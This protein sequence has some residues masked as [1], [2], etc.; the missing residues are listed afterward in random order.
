MSSPRV[1]VPPDLLA[2]IPQAYRNAANIGDSPAEIARW[3]SERRRNFPTDAV[4]AAKRARAVEGAGRGEEPI[5]APLG[6]M[7]RR[8]ATTTSTTATTVDNVIATTTTKIAASNADDDADDANSVPEEEPVST[9]AVTFP[10][11]RKNTSSTSLG[12]GGQQHPCRTF[13]SKGK[14]RFGSS[15]RFSHA[16]APAASTRAAPGSIA[17]VCRWY[18]LGVCGAGARCPYQ[19]AGGGGGGGGGS[20]SASGGVGVGTNG[21]DGLLRRLL[22]KDVQRETSMLLQ[23]IRFLKR[24]GALEESVV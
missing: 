19:H 16:A 11:T 7:R 24:E 8:T 14:C 10:L 18:V 22:S 12:G 1:I 20:A 15:C 23:A 6:K 2:L 17:S 3:K 9:A 21:P 13:F 5:A 4:I